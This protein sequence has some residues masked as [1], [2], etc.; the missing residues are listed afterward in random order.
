MKMSTSV[1]ALRRVDDNTMKSQTGIFRLA[2]SHEEHEIRVIYR[3][4]ASKCFI[5]EHDGKSHPCVLHMQKD[6]SKN[7]FPAIDFMTTESQR[8]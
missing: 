3:N 4:N 2:E 1:S 7:N 6:A 8:S 5:Y